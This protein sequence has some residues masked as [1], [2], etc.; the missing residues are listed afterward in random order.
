[1]IRTPAVAGS[2]YPGSK[3][4][5]DAQIESFDLYRGEPVDALG[6]VAPHAGYMYSGPVAA[7]VYSRIR[8]E[9]SIL[10]IGP[11]HGS[12]RG[13]GAPPV[14]VM[15]DGSWELPTGRADIDED[16][17]RSLMEH[18]PLIEE[19]AWAHADEHSLEVQAPFVH[20]FMGT[21]KI[22]PVMMARIPD[23]EIMGLAAGIYKAVKDWD[24]PVT[25]IAST[26]FSHYVPHDTAVETDRLALDRIEALDAPGLI[27]VVRK[28]NISMCG[29]QPTAV[30]IE[31]CR[32][33]GATEARLVGYQTS[34][35]VSGDYSS[36]VGYGG[37]VIERPQG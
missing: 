25:L 3:S 26:D 8:A 35:E 34:G 19:A 31:V 13:Y 37:F 21:P 36:V 6:A 24:P 12:G 17:A 32:L 1:M 10:I 23:G 20:H 14:A 15:A 11:N 18:A 33:M 4:A 30:V 5:I 29:A 28:N 9:G 2:F 27:D 7:K 22:V 16:L